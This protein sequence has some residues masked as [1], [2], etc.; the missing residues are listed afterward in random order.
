MSY[1][2]DSAGQGRLTEYFDGIGAILGNR[3]RRQSFAIYAYG[4]L[5]DGER[6]SVEPMAARACGDPARARAM[7]EKLL[8]FVADSQWDDATVRRYAARYALDAMQAR[9]KVEAWIIDDTGFIKQGNMSPGVQRQYTGS[10]GKRTNCQIAVSL[11][12]CTKTEQLPVDMDLYLPK[13]WMA[14]PER[15]ERARIPTEITYRPKWQMALDIIERTL[16]AGVTP[17][18]VLADSGYGDAAA[19]RDGLHAFGL[20]YAVDVKLHTRVRLTGATDASPKTVRDLAASLDR[21]AFRKVTWREGTREKL[22]SRFA[23]VR[24][25]VEHSDGEFRAEQWLLIEHPK[26]D[27]EPSH[28]VLSTLRKNITRKELVRIVK[29][30]WRIE[31]TYEDL[32]G[33]LGLDH[34]E[35]RS[36]PGWQHHV[37]VVLSCYSFVVAERVRHFPPSQVRAQ[38]NNSISSAA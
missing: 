9:E 23:A 16:E 25:T 5:G 6:K 26:G 11:T 30:R 19:F 32:K 13:G 31:R 28:Y 37:S 27:D 7:Q 12:V 10:A 15:C 36:Y 1:A 24:V 14:T 2:M 20:D 38:T 21:K 8:H 29:Q 22:C 3:N 33:E 4:I 17:G 18:V 35:G 34:F